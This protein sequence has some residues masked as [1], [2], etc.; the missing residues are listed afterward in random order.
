MLP[1]KAA[2]SQWGEV[3]IIVGLLKDGF[4]AELRYAHLSAGH[5]AGY[6]ENLCRPKTVDRT[7][8]GTPDSDAVADAS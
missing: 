3:V 6:A 7:L 1:R 5:L 4:G 2:D 8:S